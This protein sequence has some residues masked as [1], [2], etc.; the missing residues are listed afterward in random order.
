MELIDFNLFEWLETA[1]PLFFL[2]LLLLLSHVGGKVANYFKAPRVTGYLVVGVL[3][4]PSVLGLFHEKLVKED[5]TLVTHI[6]LSII[7]FSIGGALGW[8]KVKRLGKHILWITLAQASGAFLVVTVVLSLAF[9]LLHGFTPLAP[10][11][12][13]LYL[14][15]ALMIGALSSATAPAATLAIVHEYK[16]KGPLTAILLGVVALDDALAIFFF[17][18]AAAIAH[19]LVNHEAITWLSVLVSP[20]LSI[21]VSLGIGGAIGMSLRKL[22]RF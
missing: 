9:F 12:L 8:A 19:S 13:T 22:I 7:A 11:F 5:L 4:S 16:A 14:P 1:H 21:L 3:L 17:A 18:F 15:M 10:S 2:G 6:A 20:V